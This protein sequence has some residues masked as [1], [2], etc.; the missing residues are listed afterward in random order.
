MPWY[1]NRNGQRLWYEDK[2][3]GHTLVMVHGWCMSSAVWKYQFDD[4]A[5]SFRVVAPDLRGH[6]RSQQ[7]LSGLNMDSFVEDLADLIMQL[8]LTDVVLVGWSMGGEV[9]L[10]ASAELCGRLAA[11]V[12][13]ST[14]PSFTATA[15]FP[16][17]LGC[18][19]VRGMRLKV[20]RNMQRARAGFYGNMFA[21]GELEGNPASAE[22]IQLLSEI[23]LP[24]SNAVLDSLDVLAAADMRPLLAAINLPTLVVNGG[25]DKICLPQ[26]SSYLKK[27]IS[28]AVQY[29]FPQCG[30]VPFLTCRDRFNAELSRFVRRTSEK[31][32]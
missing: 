28:G 8:D 17:G 13:V 11:L 30:H 10:G 27:N 24:D 6:G 12:L 18:G 2:G 14:T 3:E 31:N 7:A 32:A 9:V 1:E 22:I 15:D 5:T 26:A 29:V 25:M 20:Q 16:Y 21:D 19:E 23:P 4:L